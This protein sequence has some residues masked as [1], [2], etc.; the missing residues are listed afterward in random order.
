MKS[1]SDDAC[2]KSDAG[3]DNTDDDHYDNVRTTMPVY[4]MA[5]KMNS[6]I[7]V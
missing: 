5:K 6:S 3:D 2:S 7:T 4:V 1:Y